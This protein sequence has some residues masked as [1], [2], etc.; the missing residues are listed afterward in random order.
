LHVERSPRL[1]Y[2]SG[3]ARVLEPSGS[4]LLQLLPFGR[5]HNVWSLQIERPGLNQFD[6]GPLMTRHL[7]ASALIAVTVLVTRISVSPETP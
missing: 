1:C 6:I 2:L 3:V 7:D 5:I 4:V